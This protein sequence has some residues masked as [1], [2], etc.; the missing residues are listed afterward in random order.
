MSA[1]L[2]VEGVEHLC[3]EREREREG[4]REGGRE[5]RTRLVGNFVS[6][7]DVLMCMSIVTHR[8][9]LTVISAPDALLI[10]CM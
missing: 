2:I 5:C 4:G 10:L 6:V 8:L 1:Y 9:R 3:V 7:E